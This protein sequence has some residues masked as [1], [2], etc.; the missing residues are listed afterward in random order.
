MFKFSCDLHKSSHLLYICARVCVYLL[1]RGDACRCPSVKF[2]GNLNCHCLFIDTLV[3]AHSIDPSFAR[4]RRASDVES[5]CHRFADEQDALTL[6]ERKR[7]YVISTAD[8]NRMLAS[9]SRII[10]L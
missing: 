5:S 7:D 10:C 8:A 2:L 3:V 9:A 6:I 1:A 4:L